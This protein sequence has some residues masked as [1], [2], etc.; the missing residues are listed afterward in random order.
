MS[1]K[2]QYKEHYLSVE[3]L[4]QL[5]RIELEL[6]IEFDRICQKH[7]LKYSIDGGT[8]LG[9]VR[10][11]GFIPWDDDADVIMVRSEYEKFMLACETELDKR[12]FYFQDYRN[13]TGYRWGYGKLRRKGTQFVRLNQEHMPYE[14]G[15][16]LDVFPC[17]NVPDNYLLRSICNFHCFLY[18]K[19]FWAAVA[20]KHTKGIVN[21]IY[22]CLYMIP[23]KKLKEHYE[24]YV[25]KRNKKETRLVKCLTFP[26]CNKVLGYDR[27]WYEKTAPIKFE[28]YVFCGS[29]DYQGYL[30]FLYGDYMTLPPIEKR[31]AHPVSKLVL[32]EDENRM[33]GEKL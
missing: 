19:V 1:D 2:Y 14:Q 7:K 12:R 25:R 30:S 13:T 4:C 21:L 20:R 10:H 6:L 15:V 5:Q 24:R 28:N 8:L 23:E 18:R 26:P 29:E 11:K 31:K 27:Q 9:A 33:R 17:D 22:E 3:E 16:F 32:I